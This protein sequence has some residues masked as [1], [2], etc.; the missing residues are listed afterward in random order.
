MCRFSYLAV[1]CQRSYTKRQRS[2]GF[3][4]SVYCQ[5]S[6]GEKLPKASTDTLAPVVTFHA[7]AADFAPTFA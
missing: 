4:G 6:Y 7:P 3:A 1:Y 2:E 5:R